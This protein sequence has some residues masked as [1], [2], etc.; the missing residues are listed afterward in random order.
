MEARISQQ[1][2]AKAE[3]T[4]S[5]FDLQD[6][7]SNHYGMLFYESYDEKQ[8]LAKQLGCFLKGLEK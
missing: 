4:V 1:K 5:V 2:R 6:I 3:E 7:I 8:D